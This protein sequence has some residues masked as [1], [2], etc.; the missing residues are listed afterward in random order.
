MKSDRRIDLLHDNV[1]KYGTVF[2]TVTPGTDLAD[3]V[4]VG[5]KELSM[6]FA[7]HRFHDLFVQL[8]LPN[9]PHEIHQFLAEHRPVAPDIELPNAPFW[10]PAQASFLREALEQD[11]NW[12]ELA[13]Q[14]SEALRSPE[15][16]R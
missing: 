16:V 12:S 7:I 4:I 6:E 8:G 14:L 10:T 2:N 1:K 9:Q 15:G 11:S 13:D 5:R 3:V